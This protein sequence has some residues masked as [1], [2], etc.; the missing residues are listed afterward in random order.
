MKITTQME[1]VLLQLTREQLLA[2]LQK[3]A[4]TNAA[5]M[6]RATDDALRSAVRTYL[7]MDR[8]TEAQINQAKGAA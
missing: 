2:L 8:L 1:G 5:G 3:D 4:K 7:R 6:F